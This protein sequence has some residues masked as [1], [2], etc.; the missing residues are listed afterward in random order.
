ME[1]GGDSLGRVRDVAGK[2]MVLIS[3]LPPDAMERTLRD[4]F[5]GDLILLAARSAVGVE[6]HEGEPF[7]VHG[8]PGA[9]IDYEPGRIPH[10][11]V[12]RQL[13]LAGP[14]LGA[15][16]LPSD[17]AAGQPRHVLR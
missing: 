6:A 5:D 7:V 9:S 3:V 10:R 17:P 11:D 1:S 13:Q 12:R 16:Q 2:P 15:A 14:D 4:F 8:V